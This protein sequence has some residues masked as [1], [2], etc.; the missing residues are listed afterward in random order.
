MPQ[1]DSLRRADSHE[2]AMTIVNI[3]EPIH[4]AAPK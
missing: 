4:T 2:K 3:N 1:I